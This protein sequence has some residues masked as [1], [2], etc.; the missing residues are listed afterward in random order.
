LGAY[1]LLEWTT[2]SE[3]DNDFFLVQRSAD[4]QVFET[5][6]QLDGAGQSTTSIDYLFRDYGSAGRDAFYRLEQVDHNGASTFSEVIQ[7]KR[8]PVTAQARI[9]P[10]P[11]R[12]A[13]KLVLPAAEKGVYVVS[14]LDRAGLLIRRWRIEKPEGVFEETLEAAVPPGFYTLEVAGPGGRTVIKAAGGE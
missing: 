14:M 13:F 7:V 3:S 8:L 6:G 11:F 4:G 12:E 1:N 9:E 2:A 10:V 5:I